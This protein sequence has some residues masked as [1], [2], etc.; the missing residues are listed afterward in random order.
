MPTAPLSAWAWAA[1]AAA[2]TRVKSCS[3]FEWMGTLISASTVWKP[4]F[5]R[6]YR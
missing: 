5:E 3:V 6:T 1:A 4:S 2:E